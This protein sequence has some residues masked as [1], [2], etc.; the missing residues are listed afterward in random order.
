MLLQYQMKSSCLDALL[1]IAVLSRTDALPHADSL[2]DRYAIKGFL[3]PQFDACSSR[4]LAPSLRHAPSPSLRRTPRSEA[5]PRENAPSHPSSLAR[6]QLTPPACAR[7][8]C[9]SLLLTDALLGN[10]E[11]SPTRSLALAPTYSPLR[12]TPARERAHPS[13]LPGSSTAPFS[14]VGLTR[15]RARRGCVSL[16]LT[17][18]LVGN[19]ALTPTHSL[20]PSLPRAP[21]YPRSEA[22]PREHTPSP[23]LV[24][25]SLL[26]RPFDTQPCSSRL[27][28]APPHNAL[29]RTPSPPRSDALPAPKHS[30]ESTRPLPGSSTAPSSCVRL[31]RS[32]ALRGCASLLLTTRSDALHRP[33]A[34]THS[35]L[36]ST[37]ARERAHPSLLPGSSTAPF[38]CVGLTRSRA[39]CGCVSL[40]LTDALL[41]NDALTPTHSLAPSLPRAP[42]Y[43]RSEALPREHSPSPWLVDSSLLLRPFDT[44]P[45]SSRLRVAPPD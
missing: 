35:P 11:L 21:S 4:S 10:D 39:R 9:V 32:R 34:P 43:P 1:R 30:R 26:L 6:R 40:L 14:C 33:L 19:D 25:S 42:S 37:P 41:G 44:Q 7:R 17:D 5:L 20:A 8:G 13:L 45:C 29:R 31:T 27:R 15:S 3:S 28:V 16:L 18:A 24:D 38:S 22:L 23:W 36:R 2:S 12:S